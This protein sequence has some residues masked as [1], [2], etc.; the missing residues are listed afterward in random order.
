MRCVCSVGIFVWKNKEISMRLILIRHGRQ[1]SPL[2]NVDVDLAE[3]GRQQAE[4][5]AKRLEGLAPDRI[6]TSALTRAKQTA[7]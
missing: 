1:S 6:Y 7:E 2:C 5:L 3:V 4:L